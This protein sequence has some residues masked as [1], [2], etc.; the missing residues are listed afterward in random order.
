MLP[1]FRRR[2]FSTLSLGLTLITLG[3]AILTSVV[4][5]DVTGDAI[6]H[7]FS[8][9][10]SLG[11][12]A[13]TP[14]GRIDMPPDG[15][16][17]LPTIDQSGASASANA[18]NA[19]VTCTSITS[20]SEVVAKCAS[21]MEDLSIGVSG[22]LTLNGVALV[23][24]DYVR[25]VSLSTDDGSGATSQDF[26]GMEDSRIDNLC[27]VQDFS[28][29]LSPTCQD[30]TTPETIPIN[31]AVPLVG[32]VTGSVQVLQ[33]T[34]RTTDP[35]SGG[36]GSGLTV[37]AITVSLTVL[38]ANAMAMDIVEADSF[39]GDVQALPTATPTDTP[40]PTAT[41][42]D[43]P[44]PT[45]TPTDTPVP[46]ATPTDTPVLTALRLRTRRCPPPRRRTHRYR[47]LRP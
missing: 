17:S 21:E 11:G 35:G 43:T 3:L 24:A 46:T 39:V 9:E 41:P 38:G 47:R 16:D 12:I 22:I 40:I 34:T 18:N 15:S 29:L 10:G 4:S 37:T 33:E 28:Q 30:V 1:S 14:V 36:S 26:D 8:M 23:S 42:T 13:I 45:A 5:A 19:S 25:A 7:A 44:V 32:N 27:V 31:I 2:R 20:G 6:G